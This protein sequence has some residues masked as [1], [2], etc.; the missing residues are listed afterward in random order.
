M[1]VILSSS[2]TFKFSLI[3]EKLKHD[4]LDKD[5][6]I[7]LECLIHSVERLPYQKKKKKMLNSD[8]NFFLEIFTEFSVIGVVDVII[9]R[10]ENLLTIL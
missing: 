7:Q 3:K 4:I 10:L 6:V 5:I 9:K 8:D 2:P 1:I